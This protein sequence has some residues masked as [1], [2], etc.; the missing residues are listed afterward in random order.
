MESLECLGEG[1]RDSHFV[2]DELYNLCGSL[3]VIELRNEET[4]HG[5]Q[6]K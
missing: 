3:I 5:H 2:E 4:D 6:I 1:F